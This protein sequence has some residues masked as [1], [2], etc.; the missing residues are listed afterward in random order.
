[1]YEPAWVQVMSIYE[2]LKEWNV[3]AKNYEESPAWKNGKPFPGEES[4]YSA[5]YVQLSGM[6]PQNLTSEGFNKSRY[7]VKDKSEISTVLMKY[8]YKIRG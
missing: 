3:K 7:A 5:R 4:E 1:M 2:T 8:G 6:K